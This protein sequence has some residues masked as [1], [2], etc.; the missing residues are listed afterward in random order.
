MNDMKLLPLHQ[1]PLIEDFQVILEEMRDTKE[2]DF[3][4]YHVRFH[5]SSRGYIASFP[6]W[7]CAEKD[8]RRDDF[9]TP[10]GDFMTPFSD[11]E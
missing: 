3:F 9:S 4:G 6:W 2:R 11:L 1:F 7:D 8:M 5:S 10:L